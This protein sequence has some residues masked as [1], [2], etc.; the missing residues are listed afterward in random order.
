V[1][2]LIEVNINFTSEFDSSHGLHV[3]RQQQCLQECMKVTN[4]DISV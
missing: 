3:Q 4:F 1:K 2:C